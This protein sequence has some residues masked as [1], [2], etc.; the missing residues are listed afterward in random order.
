MSRNVAYSVPSRQF[1]LVLCEG[2]G[3]DIRLRKPLVTII[4]KRLE[5][6]SQG[7][8]ANRSFSGP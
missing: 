3:A 1:A 4:V 7:S 5:E 2:I 8:R 6:D